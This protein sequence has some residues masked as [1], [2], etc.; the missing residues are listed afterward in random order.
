[1]ST[2]KWV[3][4]YCRRDSKFRVYDRYTDVANALEVA[5]MLLAIR[6]LGVQQTTIVKI[7]D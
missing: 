4:E 3:M 6:E 2:P 7:G 5:H 1:M